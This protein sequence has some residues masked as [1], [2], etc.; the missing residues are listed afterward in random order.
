MRVYF[1][2]FL[3]L[4]EFYLTLSSSL[5][6][7]E[8]CSPGIYDGVWSHFYRKELITD[9]QW[10]SKVNTNDPNIIVRKLGTPKRKDKSSFFW[11]YGLRR[12]TQNIRNCDDPVEV[13][14]TIEYAI[15][16]VEFSE[17]KPLNCSVI[18][19]TFIG[20]N[21]KPDPWKSHGLMMER[22]E[23]SCH[24]FLKDQ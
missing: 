23:M 10:L 17:K 9:L 13:I 21:K 12:K 4:I 19:K 15:I 3:I 18:Q 20:P 8:I 2:F 22:S 14:Y 1:I 11:I 24:D 7:K 6:S 5:Y 16:K